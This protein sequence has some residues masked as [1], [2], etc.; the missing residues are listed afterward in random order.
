MAQMENLREKVWCTC[1]EKKKLQVRAA[2]PEM[3]AAEVGGGWLSGTSSLGEYYLLWLFR[4]L[5]NVA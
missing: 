5:L 1:A 4:I 2:W 3:K